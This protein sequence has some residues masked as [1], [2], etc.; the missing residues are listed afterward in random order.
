MSFELESESLPAH[1]SL[2]AE[3]YK[4]LD[5]R[6]EDLEKKVDDLR[7][8]ITNMRVSFNKALWTAAGSIVVAVITAVGLFFSRY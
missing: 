2:C 8:I 3:R 7:D 5:K 1:V 4:Q 6:L